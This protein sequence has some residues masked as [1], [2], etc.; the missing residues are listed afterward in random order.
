MR[1]KTVFSEKTWK[2][3]SFL[4]IEAFPGI[5]YSPYFYFFFPIICFNIL[6][7]ALKFNVSIN[8]KTAANEQ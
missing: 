3:R 5:F 2:I 6:T 4:F 7:Q 1:K 8:K